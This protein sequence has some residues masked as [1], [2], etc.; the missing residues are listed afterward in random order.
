ATIPAGPQASKKA[1][2][3]FNRHE[4][5]H[6]VNHSAAKLLIGPCHRAQT[7]TSMSL[8]YLIRQGFPSWIQTHTNGVPL[9]TTG[10]GQSIGEMGHGSNHSHTGKLI[11]LRFE[12]EISL[13]RRFS[14]FF[15]LN[16]IGGLE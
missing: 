13:K 11:R 9:G 12:V 5:R 6:H 8:A 14:Y 10:R 2:C 1:L 16:M 15:T 4:R 3:G 7:F